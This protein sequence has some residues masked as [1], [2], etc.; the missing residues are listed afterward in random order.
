MSVSASNPS[1][2][3]P[4]KPLTSDNRFAGQTIPLLVV[5]SMVMILCVDSAIIGALVTPLKAAFHLTDEQLGR[6]RFVFSLVNVILC[7]ILGYVGDRFPRKPFMLLSVGVFSLATAAGGLAN[8]FGLL[9]VTRMLVGAGSEGFQLLWPSFITDLFGPNWRNAAFGFVRITGPAGWC[10]GFLLA[11]W[12]EAKYGWKAAFYVGGIPGIVLVI[13]GLFL[14]HEPK[15][16]AVDGYHHVEVPEWHAGIRLLKDGKFWVYMLGSMFFLIAL[17]ALGDWGPAY[18]HRFYGLA[19]QHATAFFAY[20]WLFFQAT[21]GIIGGILGSVL[22]RRFASGYLYMLGIALVCAA[23]L[24]F[25]GLLSNDLQT[26]KNF[27][28]AEMFFA[29]L[30]MGAVATVM[31][32]MVPVALRTN[33]V[34][35]N[36]LMG[37]I[38]GGFLSSELIGLLSDRFGLNIGILV[39]PSAFALSALSWW[40]L[41]AIH[42]FEKP[43]TKPLETVQTIAS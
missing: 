27:I 13:A 1:V 14:L 32:D 17:S 22:K 38:L 6:M 20:G 41:L 7:P 35:F 8:G 21:G 4:G 30:S 33:A 34:S 40:I 28:R 37:G 36:A 18:L 23:A 19:N 16:G 11:G 24:L 39:V 29:G 15:R 25:H 43:A 5:F 12:I 3:Q 26:A 10:I 42:W 2:A 31:M 9:L